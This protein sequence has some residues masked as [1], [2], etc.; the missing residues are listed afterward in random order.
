MIAAGYTPYHA[1]NGNYYHFKPL[2][3]ELQTTSEIV[4]P[5]QDL[6]IGGQTPTFNYDTAVKKIQHICKNLD[7]IFNEEGIY[8]TSQGFNLILNGDIIDGMNI[9]PSQPMYQEQNDPIMQVAWA[10]DAL[11]PVIELGK[12]FEK[13]QIYVQAGN[14]GMVDKRAHSN[15]NWEM[16]LGFDLRHLF[17]ADCVKIVNAY[18]PQTIEICNTTFLIH[19]GDCVSGG[20]GNVPLF[21]LQKRFSAWGIEYH[22]DIALVGHWHSLFTIPADNYHQIY[23]SG[24]LKT[25]DEYCI[26]N[27][28]RDGM[29]EG[30]MFIVD[31][32]LPQK[33]RRQYPIY[34]NN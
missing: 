33:I 29:N 15:T 14:H 32:R 27:F 17:G 6:H 8:H 26:R 5:L 4:F 20:G 7:V 3:K 24:T 25:D 30:Y 34:Y 2:E 13:F 21:G 12:K 22:Y 23:G 18:T 16:L 1:T 11:K 10:V 28:G 19:H 9:Y 31:T